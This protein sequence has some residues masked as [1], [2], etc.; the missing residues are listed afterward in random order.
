MS[1]DCARQPQENSPHRYRQRRDRRH[2][3]CDGEDERDRRSRRQQRRRS[4]RIHRLSLL[5]GTRS[6]GTSENQHSARAKGACVVHAAV[7]AQQRSQAWAANGASHTRRNGHDQLA[8]MG[9]AGVDAKVDDGR[10]GWVDRNRQ[11]AQQRSWGSSGWRGRGRCAGW[12]ASRARR[13]IR[14]CTEKEHC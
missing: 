14:D 2:T 4:G 3:P 8:C 11:V 13:R 12:R 7:S 9:T 10:S 1:R 6:D 5:N